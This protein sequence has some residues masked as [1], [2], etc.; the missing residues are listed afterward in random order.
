MKR[1]TRVNLPG[2]GK[3]TIENRGNVKEQEVGFESE[4]P[5]RPQK[6]TLRALP[7]NHG[8]T[9]G[10]EMESRSRSQSNGNVSSPLEGIEC[11]MRRLLDA[12]SL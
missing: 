3:K 9:R 4:L 5:L 7:I 10:F 11:I 8:G 1:K 2:F 6:T 12:R